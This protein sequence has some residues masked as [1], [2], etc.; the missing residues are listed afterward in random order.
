MYQHI[1]LAVAL[2]QW[3]EPSPH[4]LAAR[5]VAV[6][7]AKGAGAK[8]SVL[9]VYDHGPP[10]ESGLPLEMASHSGAEVMRQLEAVRK[11]REEHIRQL[12]AQ[13]ETKIKVF[14]AGVPERDLP[15]APLL[16]VGEPRPLIISTAETLGVD[17]IVI[18]GHSKRSFLDVL[19]GGTAAY[20]SRHA[21]CPVLMVQPGPGAQR[22]TATTA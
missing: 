13:M 11:R 9:S 3:E 14:A 10:E 21:A 20:V 18:G 4:A 19:L 1:L 8:L 15:I 22:R 12:D 17:L 5:E 6:T 7:L 16:K 2:Q